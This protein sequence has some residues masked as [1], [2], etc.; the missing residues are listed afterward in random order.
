MHQPANLRSR[1][2]LAIHPRAKAARQPPACLAICLVP[3]LVS[4]ASAPT[5]RATHTAPP[6]N[7]RAQSRNMA[8]CKCIS[9]DSETIYRKTTKCPLRDT[10]PSASS[11]PEQWSDPSHSSEDQA[12]E[13]ITNSSATPCKSVSWLHEM[14]ARYIVH[15]HQIQQMRTAFF[16]IR[17]TSKRTAM[18]SANSPSR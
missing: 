12:A 3:R 2:V 14:A 17:S 1:P 16:F 7:C 5:Q 6:Q 15:Y 11:H 8:A 4:R 18:I 10:R 13:R 9:A